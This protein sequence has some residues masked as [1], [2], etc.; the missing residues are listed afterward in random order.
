MR[1]LMLGWEFPPYIAGGLGT[2]CYGLTR[3]LNAMGTDVIFV[4]PRPVSHA[5]GTSQ[6]S[7]AG[8]DYPFAA[9]TS[10]AAEERHDALAAADGH[11]AAAEHGAPDSPD[12]PGS[13]G[14][15]PSEQAHARAESPDRAGGF[16]GAAGLANVAVATLPG[17]TAGG[18]APHSP[19]VP[20][21]PAR[22]SHVSFR[23][24]DVLLQPYMSAEEY[25]ARRVAQARAEQERF[26]PEA[27]PVPP[28]VSPRARTLA[29]LAAGH[30]PATPR[31]QG[32]K[33]AE[34]RPHPMD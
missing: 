3:A 18:L 11:V 10:S 31:Q 8:A 6:L 17:P 27:A 23:T 2:A 14:G 13:A 9:R 34:S 12:A 26:A 21:Q 30:G 16:A 24:L 33:H 15:P 28:V 29:H 7:L 1:V 32:A 20:D 4:L 5:P 22:L 19:L 25:R